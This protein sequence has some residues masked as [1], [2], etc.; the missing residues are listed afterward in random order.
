M[1]N[2][3]KKYVILSILTLLALPMFASGASQTVSV[4][5]AWSADTLTPQYYSGRKLPSQ[6]SQIIVEAKII[7]PSVASKYRY[8]WYLDGV[9]QRDATGSYFKFQTTKPAGQN[10]IIKL[11]LVDLK[12]NIVDTKRATIPVTSPRI[13]FFNASSQRL[14]TG[15]NY[16]LEDGLTAVPGQQ[17]DIVA[18]PYYLNTSNPSDVE[19]RWYF[20]GQ[21]ATPASSDTPEI[22]QIKLGDG[23][24][25]NILSYLLRTEIFLKSNPGQSI[26]DTLNIFVSGHE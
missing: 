11:E 12:Q 19:Y 17:I 16:F 4:D 1:K 10:H 8:Q 18:A 6:S 9:I 7:P 2:Y 15:T 25:Q 13:Y 20:G 22:L 5:I 21:T 24:L 3:F 23:I 26:F 14:I